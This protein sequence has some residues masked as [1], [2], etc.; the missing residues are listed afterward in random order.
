MLELLGEAHKR[1]GLLRTPQRVANALT[2]LTRG[3][4]LTAAEVIGDA[5]FEEPHESMIL[6]RDIELYSLCE[7]HLLPF[8]GRA[9]VA[10]IPHGKIVGLSK[11]PRIVEVY[12]RRLQV[13][14]RLTEEIAQALTDALAPARGRRRRGGCAP[15]H[16]D[17]GRREAELEDDHLGRPRRLPHRREDPE[18]SSSGSR[19]A[20]CR[21]PA[22]RPADLGP[23]GYTG[24]WL[25]CVGTWRDRC[26][27]LAYARFTPTS[28]ATYGTG[29]GSRLRHD[30]RPRYGRGTVSV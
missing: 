17:A 3:Y 4:A 8:F 10:Y 9:H 12:A 30:D 26:C 7:Y 6:G 27:M 20:R 13:Q 18:T 23:A 1:A 22:E 15:L 28:E 29:Q 16:D 19:T 25:R 11:I 5:I 14:E 24:N 21:S 2:W